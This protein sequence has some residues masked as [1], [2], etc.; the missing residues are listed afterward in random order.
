LT[1]SCGSLVTS[2]ARKSSAL[3]TSGLNGHNPVDLKPN[4]AFSMVAVV[5]MKVKM[6]TDI[7]L[8]ERK[9]AN[10]A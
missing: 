3:K 8:Q 2:D 10:Q 4:T 9:R 7:L 5:M 6:N 1:G